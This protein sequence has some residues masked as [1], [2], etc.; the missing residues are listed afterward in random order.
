MLLDIEFTRR[1]ESLRVFEKINKLCDEAIVLN[2]AVDH[3]QDRLQ[4]SHRSRLIPYNYNM[5]VKVKR[6]HRYKRFECHEFHNKQINRS[7][8]SF[9][10]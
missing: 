9:V 4:S 6:R 1:G 7:D 8:F 2:L 3:I 5:H 10:V